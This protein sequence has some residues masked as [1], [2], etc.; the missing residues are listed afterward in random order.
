MIHILEVYF[1]FGAANPLTPRSKKCCDIFFLIGNIF[2]FHLASFLALCHAARN[3][4]ERPSSFKGVKN[5]YKPYPTHSL[6]S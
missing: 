1:I 5:F 2:N 4:N 3:V 6:S